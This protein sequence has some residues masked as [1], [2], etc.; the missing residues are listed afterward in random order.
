MPIAIYIFIFL[1]TPD[2]I[3]KLLCLGSLQLPIYPP[4]EH[5]NATGQSPAAAHMFSD[6]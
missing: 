6:R 3:P 2:G 4:K 1:H 5:K